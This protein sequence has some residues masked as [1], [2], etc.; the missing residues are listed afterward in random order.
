MSRLVHA[1]LSVKIASASRP[2]VLTVDSSHCAE[3]DQEDFVKAEY[4]VCTCIAGRWPEA[5]PLVVARW[6]I[7]RSTMDN[8]E[9]EGL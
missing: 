8:L 2:E 5:R 9:R 6:D 3:H 4:S 7:G 1:G